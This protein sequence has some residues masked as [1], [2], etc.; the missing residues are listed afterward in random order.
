MRRLS[1]IIILV[2]AAGYYFSEI[3]KSSDLHDTLE[4]ASKSLPLPIWLIIFAVGLFIFGLSIALKPAEEE[5]IAAPR[6]PISRPSTTN[7]RSLKDTRRI[8]EKKEVADNTTEGDPGKSN[9]FI[10]EE[11]TQSLDLTEAAKDL[12][13]ITAVALLQKRADAI[14]WPRGSS[15]KID[16]GKDTP[17]TL[18]L[19]GITPG[20][21]KRALNA[22][23]DFLAEIP[24]PRRACIQTIKIIDSGIPMHRIAQGI[25]RPKLQGKA[26]TLTSQI[27]AVDIRFGQPDEFWAVK[28]N[29]E[30]E[31]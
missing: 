23:G 11:P 27:D 1:Y 21:A 29:L 26:F 7:K 16:T 30:K 15:L 13:R 12:T 31:F 5:K 28:G 18:R 25:L 3:D 9:D 19:E 20:G 6:K 4:Q 22:F 24:T 10:S 8:Q 17:F 14:D 2:S